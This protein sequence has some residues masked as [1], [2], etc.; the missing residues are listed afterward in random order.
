MQLIGV[1]NHSPEQVI[2]WLVRKGHKQT[3]ITVVPHGSHLS[4][5][6]AKKYKRMILFPT[7][8]DFRRSWALLTDPAFAS[9]VFFVHG[10]PNKLYEF[11]NMVF[12]DFD[13]Q[14]GQRSFGFKLYSKFKDI[15]LKLKGTNVPSRCKTKYFM[16]NLIEAVKQG[17]LLNK[18]MSAIYTVKG[19]SNQ[20]QLTLAI[21]QW[22]YRGEGI[23]VLRKRLS[24]YGGQLKITELMCTRFENILLTEIGFS[25]QEAF[26]EVRACRKK[27]IEV[28]FKEL[29][30]KYGIPDF[31]LKYI[32]VKLENERTN[33]T[34]ID[35]K[36]RKKVK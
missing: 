14:K 23:N 26:E 9:K 7:Y 34:T 25:F 29:G 6:K 31:E 1:G 22:L 18:L 28:P 35:Q 17:S 8:Q 27:K 21:C 2:S 32:D 16:P 15:N 33:K 11:D 10:T 4:L 19:A 20:K 5:D 12:A 24:S 36:A 30:R 3:A 13:L